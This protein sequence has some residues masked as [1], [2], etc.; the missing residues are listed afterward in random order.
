MV[1]I[2]INKTKIEEFCR[3][4]QIT[5]F[6]LF[7]S[8]VREDFRPESDV[9]VLVDFAP[10]A[11]WSLFDMG[12]MTVDLQELFGREVDLLTR[13]QIEKSENYIR[14]KEVLRTLENVYAA[15]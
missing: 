2:P 10:G 15:G 3:K 11:K 5:E 4:W 8:V 1:R 7:G 12:E 14:R 6:S 9:D 13:R